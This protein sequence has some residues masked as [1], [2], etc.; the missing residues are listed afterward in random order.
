MGE[1][2]WLQWAGLGGWIVFG[3]IAVGSTW[4]CALMPWDNDD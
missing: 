1:W 4:Y 3:I 2:T